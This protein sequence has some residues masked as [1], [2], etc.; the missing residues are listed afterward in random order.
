MLLIRVCLCKYHLQDDFLIHSNVIGVELANI[1]LAKVWIL[2]KRESLVRARR[3]KWFSMLPKTRKGPLRLT[4][5]S[6]NES[7]VEQAKDEQISDFIRD[8]CVHPVY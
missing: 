2:C 4:T 8:K 1:K 6:S 5:S 7:A 3:S